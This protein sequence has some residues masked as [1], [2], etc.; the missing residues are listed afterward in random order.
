MEVR[1]SRAARVAA[2]A[3]LVA[4]FASAERATAQQSGDSQAAKIERGKATFAENCSHCHGMNMVNP[5][6]ITP[7]LRKFPDDKQRFA[8]TVKNGKNGR[9]PPWGDI[10]KDK[11]IS[12][13]WAYVSSRRS[14]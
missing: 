7:D 5:G 10:L 2:L 13:L 6:T 9:M 12:D 1:F 14:P 11:D 8:T 3:L 4:A